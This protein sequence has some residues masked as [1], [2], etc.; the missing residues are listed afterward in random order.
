MKLKRDWGGLDARQAE[1]KH[2]RAGGV[3]KAGGGRGGRGEGERE[4]EREGEGR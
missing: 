1:E 3:G 4:R 2:L